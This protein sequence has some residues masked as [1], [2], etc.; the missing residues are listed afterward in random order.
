M[1]LH[2]RSIEPIPETTARIARQA[3]PKGNRYLLL[4]DGWYTQSVGEHR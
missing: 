3:F 2:P 1:S 4:R